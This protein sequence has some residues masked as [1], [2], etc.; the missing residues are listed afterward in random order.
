MKARGLSGTVT[1]FK[2]NGRKLG[3]PTANLDIPTDLKDGVYF[4]HADLAAHRNRPAL[5]FVGRPT[6]LND[7][8]RRVE[9]HLL[10][11][12]DRDYYDLP[13]QAQVEFFHRAN[14]KF[15]SL[16]DLKKAMRQDEATARQ[17]FSSGSAQ[18]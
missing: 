14:K 11:I 13:L 7:K 4:G 16:E 10:D 8:R 15:D 3:Y 2:G 9:V 12:E 6:T 5:I 18:P 1:R 17:W